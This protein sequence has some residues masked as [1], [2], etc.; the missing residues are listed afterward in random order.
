MS[1]TRTRNTA[2]LGGRLPW[3][4]YALVAL[5]LIVFFVV[6][7]PWHSVS[8]RARAAAEGLRDSSVYLA[9]DAPGMV[10]PVRAR[11]VIGDR[12]I[13]VAILDTTPLTEYAEETAPNQALCQDI[14]GLVPTNLVAVFSGDPEGTYR[15]AYCAGPNFPTPTRTEQS[16]EL[17]AFDV[18]VAAEESWQ[19]RATEDDLTPQLE[20]YV[21]TFDSKAVEA[22]GEIPR[23][24]PLAHPLDFWRLLLAGLA[25]VSLP[26]VVFVLLRLGARALHRRRS[27]KAAQRH[28]QHVIDARLNR[29]ADRILHPAGEPDAEAAR[30]Y[31]LV[32]HRLQ[33]ATTDEELTEVEN[34]IDDLERA[35][36]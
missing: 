16:A 1:R 30:E 33:D 21:L 3:W 25:M 35:M 17:F 12:A 18:L 29:L 13:V 19:Y 15:A 4:V 24:G 36:L 27:G 26:I 10:D 28:R 34:K 14:A 11:E 31:V 6:F 7:E 23:R 5:A 22:Y 9:P 20:E 8:D 32:L 2:A